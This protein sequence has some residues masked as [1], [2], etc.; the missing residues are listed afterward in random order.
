VEKR[1]DCTWRS[2]ATTRG[3]EQRLHVE[4]HSDNTRGEEQRLHVEKHS[5][6]TR[7]EEQRLHV[8]KHSDKTWRSALSER[9]TVDVITT[10]GAC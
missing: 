1:S 5:D 10:D 9:V 4:K 7:G 2:T 8:E 3:E 6:N